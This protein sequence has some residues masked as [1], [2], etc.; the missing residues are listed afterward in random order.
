MQGAGFSPSPD[1]RGATK[2][3][4]S[5]KTVVP[6]KSENKMKPRNGHLKEQKRHFTNAAMHLPASAKKRNPKH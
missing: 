4:V 5:P 6:K 1:H 2:Q 3:L